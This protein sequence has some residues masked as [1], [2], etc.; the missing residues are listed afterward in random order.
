MQLFAFLHWKHYLKDKKKSLEH[1]IV[2]FRIFIVCFDVHFWTLPKGEKTKQFLAGKFWVLQSLIFYHSFEKKRP[3]FFGFLIFMKKSGPCFHPRPMK[4]FC[5]CKYF[6][7]LTEHVGLYITV[8][9]WFWFD[10]VWYS[11][12]K[13]YC[14]HQ[15]AK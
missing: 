12:R 10:S 2:L 11:R 9:T 4:N 15:Y 3:L 13:Y 5:S 1:L 6:Y 14:Y 7:T 8:Y